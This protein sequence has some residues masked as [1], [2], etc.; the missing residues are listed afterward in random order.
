M[1]NRLED[2]LIRIPNL[3]VPFSEEA[4]DGSTTCGEGLD[5]R[6]LL[7]ISIDELGLNP[8]AVELLRARGIRNLGRLA[9]RTSDEIEGIVT[10]REQLDFISSQLEE[11]GFPLGTR[12]DPSL[13]SDDE[14]HIPN[15]KKQQEND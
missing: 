8:A 13:V 12:F 15:G 2:K 11:L 3:Y 10:D 6:L 4:D 7:S 1:S 14:L 9:S 5:L